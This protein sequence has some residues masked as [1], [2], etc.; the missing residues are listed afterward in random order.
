MRAQAPFPIQ[1]LF[2]EY[3]QASSGHR[4]VAPEMFYFRAQ[5]NP[6][7]ALRIVGSYVAQPGWNWLDDNYA[8]L[9]FG[10]ATARVGRFRS[11]FGFSNWS[12]LY[13]TPFIQLPMVRAYGF[14]F[15]PGIPLN[16][17]DRGIEIQDSFGPVQV[18]A[19]LVDSSDNDWQ[20]IP[21]Q[22]DTGVARIQFAAGSIMLGLN[23]F[24]KVADN[25]GPAAQM[26]AADFR[27]TGPR[28]QFRAEVDKGAG[29]QGATG[30]YAD[31]FYRPP[32][33][34]RTQL[35][36][37]VQGIDKPA[38]PDAWWP[39]GAYSDDSWARPAPSRPRGVVYSCALRQFLTRYFTLSVN[40][41][42]GA[43]LP[44]SK[45]LLGWSG[46]LLFSLRF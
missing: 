40:Y 32:K 7:S 27:W 22:L 31:L 8:Q 9:D 23:G 46:Q 35:G 41:G 26:V 43:N 11:D 14:N 5:A 18:Q 33:L 24:A 3:F 42:A 21:R 20:I 44:E 39:S 34:A 16:R 29:S 1:V 19:A 45:P 36:F 6:S 12:E 2:E 13:Y 28:A 15:V 17:L 37:R 4:G 10:N 38:S 30:Y 25:L